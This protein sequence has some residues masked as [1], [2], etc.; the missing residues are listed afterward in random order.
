ML[1]MTHQRL[2]LETPVSEPGHIDRFLERLQALD[3]GDQGLVLS[4][5]QAACIIDGR[6]SKREAEL[7]KRA[8]TTAGRPP[9]T[10]AALA[11]QSEFV[12]GTPLSRT[13]LLHP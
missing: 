6:L 4:M 11:L 7:L 10:E 8:Q 13:L 5:L 12:A 1:Q 9:S 2:A 3:T